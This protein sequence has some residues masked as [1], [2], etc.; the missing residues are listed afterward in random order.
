[1]AWFF[2]DMNGRQPRLSIIVPALNEEAAIVATFQITREVV[3][4]LGVSSEFLLVDDEST[5]RTGALMEN[6]AKTDRRVRVFHHER[7]KNIG[8]AFRRGVEE[9]RGEFVMMVAGDN[10]TSRQALENIIGKLG[11]ADVILSY[12]VN[13]EMRSL[14]RRFI[15]S[16]YVLFFNTLFWLK[17]RYWN[18]TFLIRRNFLLQLPPWTPGFAFIS[19]ILI[20]LVKGGA[21]YKEVPVELQPRLGGVSKALSVKNLMLVLGTIGRLV[22]RVYFSR[23]KLVL[24]KA[25][26]H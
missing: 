21:S 25:K 20:Q 14:R 7:P 24:A 15:S 19:E 22:W 2:A 12:P 26:I 13:P 17:M 10:E 16:G 6:I 18:G 5:D 4:R 9:S 3:D 23:N 1:M 8:L 11:Q